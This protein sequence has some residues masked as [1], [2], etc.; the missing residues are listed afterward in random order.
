MPS[1]R[2]LI[3]YTTAERRDYRASRR[4]AFSMKHPRISERIATGLLDRQGIRV[5]WLLHLRASASHLDGNW[6]AAIALIGIADAA[7]RQWAGR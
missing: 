5:T 1:F 3:V 6:L 2:V 4:Q 7:E